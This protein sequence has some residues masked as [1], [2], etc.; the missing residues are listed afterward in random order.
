MPERRRRNIQNQPLPTQRLR[1]RRPL[2]HQLVDRV[3][4]IHPPRPEHLVVP[5]I[6]A[7]RNRH[8]LPLHHRQRLRLRRLK[9]AL[10]VEHVVERQ[11]HLLLHKLDL[12]IFHQRRHI[13]RALA[14]R[15]LAPQRRPTQHRRPARPARQLRHLRAASPPRAAQTSLFPANPP[16]DTRTSPAPETSPAQHPAAA[17][18][19]TNSAIFRRFPR[20]VSDRRVDL[21]QR[22]PH[23][24]SLSRSQA[25]PARSVFRF[26]YPLHS[27]P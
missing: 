9:I 13:A 18:R 26:L 8:R 15:A 25:V 6:L 19:S 27:I 24:Y 1:Q 3:H 12:A 20:E 4:R 10:L 16:A 17:A 21:G 22:D 23:T 14:R 11:Q 5:R 2:P 7:D